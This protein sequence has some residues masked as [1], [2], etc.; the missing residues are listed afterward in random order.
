M[1]KINFKAASFYCIGFIILRLFLPYYNE[2]RLFNYVN[3]MLFYVPMVLLFLY[4]YVFTDNRETG[5]LVAISYLFI[6][7]VFFN[8]LNILASTMGDDIKAHELSSYEIDM[9]AYSSIVLIVFV[10]ATIL[11]LQR[12]RYENIRLIF[13][14]Y[15]M[16]VSLNI[17]VFLKFSFLKNEN[18][19]TLIEKIGSEK[20]QVPELETITTFPYDSSYSLPSGN[21]TTSQ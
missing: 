13:F 16:I 18:I 17:L 6:N 10:I 15:M 14:V 2:S 12:K 7:S 4:V 9:I 11:L 20:K 19:V 21:D 3:E 5:I 8:T 1:K